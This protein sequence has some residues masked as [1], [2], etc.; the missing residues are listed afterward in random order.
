M[1][2]EIP[3]NIFNIFFC[4]PIHNYFTFFNIICSVNYKIIYSNTTLSLLEVIVVFLATCFGL[5][6]EPS[7]G[8]VYEP[9]YV[10]RNTTKTL[11]K[12]RVVFDYIIL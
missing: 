7:S 12:L 11:N 4:L 8:S 1:G 10:D 9:K 3:D 5:Y 2:L 6:T